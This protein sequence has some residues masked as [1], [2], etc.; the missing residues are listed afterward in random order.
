[1][2]ILCHRIIQIRLIL[3]TTI[4][5]S[6]PADSRVQIV[7]Y[8]I[9]GKEVTELVNENKQAGYYE[10]NFNASHLASGIYFYKIQADSLLKPRKIILM[11]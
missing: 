4:K 2:I 1:M 6:L 9:L 11:R 10:I 5:Y 3:S 8:D 7:V